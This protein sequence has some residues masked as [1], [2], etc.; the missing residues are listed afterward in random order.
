MRRIGEERQESQR[1][2]TDK[3]PCKSLLS[4]AWTQL[5]A[6]REALAY[7]HC[8]CYT[9]ELQWPCH[10]L[11]TSEFTPSIRRLV[12]LSHLFHADGVSKAYH[13]AIICRRFQPEHAEAFSRVYMR[14]MMTR[15]MLLHC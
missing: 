8:Q 2:T 5:Q 12:H 7:N 11:Y 4:I 15:S 9:L 3:K 13:Q 6:P 14:S 1:R 10:K